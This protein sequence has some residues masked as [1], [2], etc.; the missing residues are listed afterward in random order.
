MAAEAPSG[1]LILDKPAGITS[2]QLVSQVRRKLQTRK[3]GHAGTLDPMA[4]GLMILGTGRATRL[5]HYLTKA[6][7]SYLATI[8]LGASTTSDDAEGEIISD[9]GC[10]LPMTKV[11]PQL[12]KYCGVIEQVPASV[13]AIKVAGQRAYDLVRSGISVALKARE[14]EIFRFEILAHRTFGKYLDLDVIVDCSSGTYIRSLARDLGKDLGCGGHLTALRRTRIG[15]F[16]LDLVSEELL[17]PGAIARQCFDSYLVNAAEAQEIRYGRALAIDS[18]RISPALTKHRQAEVLAML[19][20]QELLALYTT[21][22]K[23]QAVFIS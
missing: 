3:V 5:L 1:I 14:V 13:S 16:G 7:K 6:D 15:A 19:N 10:S 22:G 20:N 8:R 18:T 4:T 11:R 2:N 12:A 17:S 9:S 23:P 21:A